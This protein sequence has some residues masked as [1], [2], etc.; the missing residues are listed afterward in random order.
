[1]HRM[2]GGGSIDVTYIAR[3]FEYG[4]LPFNAVGHL[5]SAIGEEDAGFFTPGEGHLKTAG[6]CDTANVEPI[7]IGGSGGW[8]TE[9][10]KLATL[11]HGL[12]DYLISSDFCQS[13]FCGAGCD[14]P[15]DRVRN[16]VGS[17]AAGCAV[18]RAPIAGW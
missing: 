9:L 1:M 5:Q 8:V 16:K 6:H 11:Q 17:P 3:F 2:L 10:Q 15:E 12:E 13:A 7:A 4:Q 18:T 14:N